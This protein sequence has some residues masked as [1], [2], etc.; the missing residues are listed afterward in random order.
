MKTSNLGE[1]KKHVTREE[2]T[3]MISVT[4]IRARLHP[5]KDLRKPPCWLLLR[6]RSVNTDPY[7]RYFA[8]IYGQALIDR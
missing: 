8:N 1:K 5:E 4:I 6:R 7:W 3:C 2:I